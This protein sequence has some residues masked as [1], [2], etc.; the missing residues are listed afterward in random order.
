VTGSETAGGDRAAADRLNAFLDRLDHVGLEDLRLVALPVP[1]PEERA[2]LL[3]EIDRA[4]DEGGRGPLVDEARKRTRAAIERAYARHQYEPTWAGLNWGRSLG[5]TSDRLGLAI[6]AEDAAVAAV[7]DDLLD[8]DTTAA[9]AEPFEHAAGM[10][11]STT[12]PSLSLSKPNPIGWLVW[13]LLA[14]AA[15]LVVASYL[16][17][18]WLAVAGLALIAIV[19]FTS[20]RR[21]AA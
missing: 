20:W 5:T 15:V 4:A 19:A 2:A 10:S 14:A 11:G 18:I 9:L 17:G 1:D 6:A 3:A 12:T 16:V 7:M 21:P 8:E 13:I